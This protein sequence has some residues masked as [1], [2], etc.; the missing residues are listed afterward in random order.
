M[1]ALPSDGHGN[2][3]RQAGHGRHVITEALYRVCGSRW[4][5][6]S[7]RRVTEVTGD[8]KFIVP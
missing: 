5:L 6:R 3:L 1:R 2:P 4:W 8:G 7:L